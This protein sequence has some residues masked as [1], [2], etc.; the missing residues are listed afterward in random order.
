MSN[1][2]T[3]K[4]FLSLIRFKYHYTF[5][6]VIL[7]AIYF[8][9]R[10]DVSL[11][12]SLV[13]MYLSFNVLLYG[14]LYTI[15]AIADY[16]EDAQHPVKKN[17]P[18]PAKK[19]GL[20]SALAFALILIVLGLIIAFSFFKPA[21]GVIYLVFIILNLFYSFVARNIAYLDLVFNA[22]TYPLRLIM[23]IALAD[24]SVPIASLWGIFCLAIGVTCARRIVEK[25]IDRL[26]VR[27]TLR[28]YHIKTFVSIQLVCFIG[29]L[30]AFYLDKQ[31]P[32]G[33]YVWLI[34]FYLIVGFGSQTFKPV[35]RLWRQ[36]HIS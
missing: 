3:I 5:F 30:T 33:L 27:P 34:V 8:A 7:G 16:R 13:V 31:T 10:I 23:A 28:A 32:D 20:K 29:L 35:K 22:L 24:A 9:E 15:N 17:R 36:I 4:N 21:I 19:I 12:I 18:I 25:D 14:G 26:Q 2:E 1:Q 6:L 11:I